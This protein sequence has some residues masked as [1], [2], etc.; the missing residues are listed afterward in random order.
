[1]TLTRIDTENL[2]GFGAVIRPEAV[3]ASDF[4]I[5]VCDKDRAVGAAS[6]LILPETDSLELQYIFVD[7]QE[8]RKGIGRFLL[9]ETVKELEVRAL[10]ANFPESD[11]LLAFFDKTGFA[12]AADG[13]CYDI[14]VSTLLESAAVKRLIEAT[15]TDGVVTVDELPDNMKRALDSEIRKGGYPNSVCSDGIYC[16]PLSFVYTDNDT[17][18][19][20]ACLLCSRKD[21]DIVV[22]LLLSAAGDVSVMQKLF[23][24][25]GKALKSDEYS[26]SCIH[27]FTDEESVA[28]TIRTLTGGS[29]KP[30]SRMICGM[31]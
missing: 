7:P 14:P 17:K 16:A 25:F 4:A 1:M 28:D 24:A 30:S 29:A 2:D 12:L 31:L 21:D 8:R 18:S 9:T 27:L 11:D 19:P 6:F 5:G 10:F 15:K 23:S 20:V 26:G 3:E 22:E 13:D